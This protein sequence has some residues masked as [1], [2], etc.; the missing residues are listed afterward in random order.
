MKK[1]KIFPAPHVELRIHVSD[2]MVKDMHT[3]MKK[4]ELDGNGGNCGECSWG[5]VQVFNT[6][7][8]ELDDVVNK[9]MELPEAYKEE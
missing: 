8:C 1:I 6:G 3:C 5:D 7:M 2:E 4:F 9:V